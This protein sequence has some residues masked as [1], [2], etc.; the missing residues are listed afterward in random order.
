MFGSEMRL[1]GGEYKVACFV[2]D[3]EENGEGLV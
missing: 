3:L 1:V 2:A